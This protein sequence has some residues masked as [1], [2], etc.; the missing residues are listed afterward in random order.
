MVN[1][2][3]EQRRYGQGS[4]L[5][6]DRT[7][8]VVDDRALPRVAMRTILA[9]ADGLRQVGEASDGL[10]AIELVIRFRPDVVLLDVEM[11]GLSGAETA[12]AI[13]ELGP[14]RPTVIAWTVSDAADDLI[15]MIRTGC[16]GYILKDVGPQELVRAVRAALTGDLPMP[17][18]LIPDVIAK[19]II[20]SDDGNT[21]DVLTPRE[22]L[23]L[24]RL[25][26]G[27]SSK[28]IA[29]N[30]HIS[31]RSV[32]THLHNLYRKLRVSSRGQAVRA[33]LKQ[34]ILTAEDF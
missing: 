20:P 22:L 1:G 2:P 26:S 29:G 31:R 10:E 8:I 27:E 16:S 15:R 14:P 11:P 23:M 25:A 17:R 12:R 33:G 5:S 4:N 7:V 32:D 9:E 24:R 6:D 21:V 34:G 13:F 3:S 30:L 28:Q 18:R 19:A